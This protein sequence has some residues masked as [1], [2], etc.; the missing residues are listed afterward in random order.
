[1]TATD[2]IILG[3]VALML[4]TGLAV[5]LVA[6]GAAVLGLARW[7][8]RLVRRRPPFPEPEPEPEHA[9]T[10]PPPAAYLACH[11]PACGHMSTPHDVTPTGGLACRDCGRVAV[12]I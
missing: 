8:T 5:W 1:M 3:L 6:I 11:T 12:Q 4:C 2:L 9:R 7:T 10:G